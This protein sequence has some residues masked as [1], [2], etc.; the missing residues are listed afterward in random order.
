M[1]VYISSDEWYPVYDIEETDRFARWTLDV[2]ANT[3]RRWKR[4]ITE[5]KQV[6][7]EIAKK[8]QNG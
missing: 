8:G 7:D 2:P 4:V 3:V 1:N 6:Q 5:F